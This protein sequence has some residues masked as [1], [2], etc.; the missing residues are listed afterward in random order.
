MVPGGCHEKSFGVKESVD[1]DPGYGTREQKWKPC[2]SVISWRKGVI[3]V[4]GM[5]HDFQKKGG[6]FRRQPPWILDKG[7]VF[8]GLKGGLIK[9]KG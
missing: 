3:S 6:V 5:V 9:T 1:L 4:E 8:H 2:S 7:G